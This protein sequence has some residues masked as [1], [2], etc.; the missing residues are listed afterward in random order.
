MSLLVLGAGLQGRAAVLDL[1]RSMPDEEL[2][3]ADLDAHEV[4][5][6]LSGL[7]DPGVETLSLNANDGSALRAL[8]RSRGVEA[9]LFLASPPL[10]DPVARAC[11]AE[12]VHMIS[13]NYTRELG[14]LHQEALT[15]GVAILPEIGLDPGIDLVLGQLAVGELD[16]V[17][18]LDS[19]GGGLPAPEVE[20]G[21]LRYKVTWSFAGVLGAYR[22]PARLL[23]QG[24]LL[25]LGA[26]EP[27]RPE[28]YHLFEVPGA[29]TFEAYPNG[30][31]LP[32]S[33][34]Y[35]LGPELQNLGRYTLRWPGHC[36]IWSA[37]TE[38]GF[39]DEQA[40]DLSVAP[41]RF[42]SEL[43]EPRL[44]FKDQE[45]DLVVLS[46]RAWGMKGGVPKEIIWD[47][48]DWRDPETGLYAMN[49]TVGFTASI[50]LQMLLDGRVS[51]RGVLHPV[52]DVPGVE[53]LEELRRRG[54][55]AR[56]RGA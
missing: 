50:A 20:S 49:R 54:I 3:V 15:R 18:G 1:R 38:L 26:G 10:Q 40:P 4:R 37:L 24:R 16:Q 55:V 42:L 17:F 34:C 56:V 30:D 21:P 14:R 31:A 22:R 29:G 19:Y 32:Y 23:R 43:L 13:T 45:R 41:L 2:L 12:G 53:L 39:L 5:R 6:R 36:A 7:V 25:E 28:N 35:G 11:I 46:V 48:I 44:Q 8:L 52:R 51:G 33:E 47:L 9:L 27:F